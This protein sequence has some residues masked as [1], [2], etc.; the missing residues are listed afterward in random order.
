MELSVE[1]KTAVRRW[2]EEGCGLSEIQKRLNEEFG[3]SMT[4]MDV[5]F[6]LIDLDVAVHDKPEREKATP[7]ETGAPDGDFSQD[8][9]GA[10]DGLVGSGVSVSLDRVVQPGALVS[11]QVR[12]S[13]GKSGKWSL[14]QMGRLALDVGEPGYRPS[15][16]DVQEFQKQLQERIAG[17]GF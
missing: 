16:E 4:Y 1:Q 13:D 3:L 11:G 7:K 8:A 14:D 10:E 9:P 12:F 2:A 15:Q 6:L 17:Q 5:R